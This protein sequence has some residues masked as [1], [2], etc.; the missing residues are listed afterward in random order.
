MFSSG[1]T[2]AL[3]KCP[4]TAP[5]AVHDTEGSLC[6]AMGGHTRTLSNHVYLYPHEVLHVRL[7]L[8]LRN[9]KVPKCYLGLDGEYLVLMSCAAAVCLERALVESSL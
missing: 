6:L 7:H 2:K 5:R 3:P 8:D 4:H 9:S 1:N